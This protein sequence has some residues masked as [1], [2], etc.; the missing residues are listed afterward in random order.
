M[1][2]LF[3]FLMLALVI[4]P[5]LLAQQ[6]LLR[7]A[8]FK[9]SRAAEADV[10]F[11]HLTERDGLSYKFATDILQDRDGM[12]WIST[13]HGLNRYDGRRFEVFRRN[14]KDPNSILHNSIYALAE[15]QNGDIWGSTEEG[16]FCY[17]KGLNAFRNF[18]A[19]DATKY[20]QIPSIV[21]DLHNQIWG[22]SAYGLVKLNQENGDW[23]YL[24]HD[25]S[26]VR[27]ISSNLVASIT[28]ASHE[29]GDGLWVATSTGLNYFDNTTSKFKNHRTV[30]NSAIFTDHPIAALHLSSTGLLWA[31]DE[32]TNEVIGLDTKSETVRYRIPLAGFIQD[33]TLGS[34]FESS[35][36][37]VWYSSR[38]YESVRI[39]YL[40]GTKIEIIRNN[41]ADPG[42]ISG[43]CIEAG[44]ED[45]DK[46]IWFA[47]SAGI[48]KYNPSKAFYRTEKLSVSYPELNKNWQ[49]TCLAQ[50]PSDE[51]WW[52]GTRNG[53]IYVADPLSSKRTLIDLQKLT[54]EPLLS[55]C[56]T[57]VDFVN[58][59]TIV[60]FAEGNTYQLDEKRYVF[61]RFGVFDSKI[62]NYRART[63]SLESDSTFLV[64]NNRGPVL[65]WNTRT[66]AVEEVVLR[67]PKVA[68]GRDYGA[69][70]LK[71]SKGMGSWLALTG[72]DL[73]YIHP[74]SK[75]IEWID[76]E[77]GMKRFQSG[78]FAS[79]EVDKDGN[80]WF[81]Y[82]AQG[83][84]QVKKL[85]DEVRSASDVELRRWDSSDGLVNEHIQSSVS[86]LEGNIWAASSNSFSVFNPQNGNFANFKINL[87]ESNSFYYN[88]LITLKNGQMLTNIKGNLVAFYPEK[89]KLLPPQNDPLISTIEVPD[90]KIFLNGSS[91]ITL[92]PQENFISIAFGSLSDEVYYGYHFEYLLEGVNSVWV[93][94]GKN[95]VATYSSLWPGTYTFRLRA[96]SADGAW[97]SDEKKIQIHIK[98]PFYRTWWFI[99]LVGLSILMLTYWIIRTRL[100][101]LRKMADL[102]GKAQLLEKEK[103]VVMYENLKQHL[104]PHFLFNSLASLGSLIRLDPRQAGDFLDKMSKVY[105]YILKTKRTKR[106]HWWKN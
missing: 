77:I 105:R 19:N 2:R 84:F 106:F 35:D 91:K 10:V 62:A 15:D 32:L 92:E 60:C 41:A 8:D 46:T 34:I 75:F 1:C 74:G 25:A 73:G 102:V 83:L 21:C 9:T 45:K 94:A 63:M 57:D 80:A 7:S 93:A 31:V 100:D 52:V 56:I 64:S 43:D 53:K 12:L 39:S 23:E 16:F 86:D 76:L 72:N 4:A 59:K 14:L 55:P 5:K 70:W 78:F 89:I 88:Y 20:P 96:K 28:L 103:T 104:N 18:R 95:A 24:V 79:M 17:Q 85:K 101:N 22:G 69:N 65:R 38:T 27:T 66:N 13:I 81:S 3:T 26:D 97:T 82:E 98:A 36:H 11:S 42:S 61:K 48:S 67:S 6:V 87:S 50:H 40:Q 30:A 29:D 68:R 71:A 58:G 37:Q 47:T 54:K 51:T 90:R 49:I 99:G 33:P 44:W